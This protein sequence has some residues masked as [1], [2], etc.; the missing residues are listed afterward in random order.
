MAAP[1]SPLDPRT[2]GCNRLIRQGAALVESSSDILAVLSNLPSPNVTE[3]GDDFQNVEIDWE[4]VEADVDQA[5]GQLLDLCSP[6]ATH[7]DEIIRQS[8]F[9][10]PIA[11]A[12]LLELELSGD[13]V[14]EGD[15]KLSLSVG[16][17]GE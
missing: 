6:T 15:G 9:P 17:S 3:P 10:Y 13:I 8:G 7:R 2:K 16:W 14:V 5:R 11:S 4:A 1:G 12:A